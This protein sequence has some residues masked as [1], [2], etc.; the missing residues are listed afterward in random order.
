MA[1]DDCIREIVKTMLN[2]EKYLRYLR[3]IS[4]SPNNEHPQTP[5]PSRST[6]PLLPRSPSKSILL[7][8]INPTL[9][10]IPRRNKKTSK[11]LCISR[12][13]S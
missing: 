8:D 11:D 6:S 3:Y 12:Y 13:K 4:P 7:P 5:S 9:E 10:K 2:D 1:T